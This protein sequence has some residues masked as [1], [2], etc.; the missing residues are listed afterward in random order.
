MRRSRKLPIAS[1]GAK[2][3]LTINET[4]WQRIESK[5]GNPL[6]ECVRKE[7]QEATLKFVEFEIFERTVEPTAKAQAIVNACKKAAM[8]FQDTLLDN[9]FGSSDASFY[10]QRLIEKNFHDTR[11]SNKAKLFDT[12]TGL[13]TSFDVACNLSLKELNDPSMPSFEKGEGWNLWIWQLT[14][15]MQKAGLP[16]G[17]R[18]DTA[19][20][21]SDKPSHFV[22]L[23]RELQEFLPDGCQQT[24]HSDDALANAIA[25][26]RVVVSGHKKRRSASE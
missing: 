1:A 18:K 3:H 8:K 21:K 23:A 24:T 14:E 15:I 4:D 11:L 26:A 2:P 16:H 19:K 13:L 10:A 5:Y 9:A 6:P 12:L 22:A 20:R 7:V 17:V 25:R